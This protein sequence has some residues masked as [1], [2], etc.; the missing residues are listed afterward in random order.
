MSL[1]ELKKKKPPH[2]FFNYGSSYSVGLMMCGNEQWCEAGTLPEY[3]IVS[4]VALQIQVRLKQNNPKFAGDSGNI[5]KSIG[6]LLVR[7]DKGSV[8]INFL[9]PG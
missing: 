7:Q 1:L 6:S 2:Y 8:L 5:G 3:S 4:S 9:F